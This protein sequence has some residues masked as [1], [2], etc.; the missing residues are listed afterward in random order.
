MNIR[1]SLVFAFF[2]L[3]CCVAGASSLKK[4]E[5]Q[6]ITKVSPRQSV[7]CTVRDVNGEDVQ[8]SR[9]ALCGPQIFLVSVRADGLY[10]WT[11]ADAQRLLTLIA[12]RNDSVNMQAQLDVLSAYIKDC[13]QQPADEH[14]YAA[15][16]ALF[17]A[18]SIKPK[19]L[20]N[21]KQW[22]VAL[23]LPMGDVLLDSLSL[24]EN[25]KD[26]AVID[27]KTGGV[28]AVPLVAGVKKKMLSDRAAGIAPFPFLYKRAGQQKVD[29]TKAPTKS[30]SNASR[31]GRTIAQGIF[32]IVVIGSVA[33]LRISKKSAPDVSSSL[34]KP[35]SRRRQQGAAR[36][37]LKLVGGRGALQ[38]K[39]TMFS[40]FQRP[41]P[42]VVN[43]TFERMKRDLRSDD[44]VDMEEEWLCWEQRKESHL[45]LLK[46]GILDAV[47]VARAIGIVPVYHELGYEKTKEIFGEDVADSVRDMLLAKSVPADDNAMDEDP[48]DDLTWIDAVQFVPVVMLFF[49]ATQSRVIA[50]SDEWYLRVR[51][52]CSSI[53]Q[54][55][56]DAVVKV[57]RLEEGLLSCDSVIVRDEPVVKLFQNYAPELFV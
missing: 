32:A 12:Q 8:V 48:A 3:V 6:S 23:T 27:A 45:R 26:L 47:A 29:Y 54:E 21:F 5:H 52:Q 53:E 50:V 20:K 39:K 14:K 24:L 38:D 2:I 19:P 11:L 22:S 51:A 9:A 36:E 4:D 41:I 28:A 43:T 57:R 15:V 37:P 44:D 56:L 34:V 49:L 18:F 13:H 7:C 35:T 55:H 16:I 42:P 10:F 33:A 25:A 31:R 40:E 17:I 46:K 30:L 1:R